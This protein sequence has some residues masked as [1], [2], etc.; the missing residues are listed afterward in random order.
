[1]TYSTSSPSGQLVSG[2]P[3]H[4]LRKASRSGSPARSARC[5]ARCSPCWPPWFPYVL[6]LAVAM[7]AISTI[8]TWGY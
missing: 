7:F 4:Y 6:T 2:D 5:W 8:I 1:M 3:M